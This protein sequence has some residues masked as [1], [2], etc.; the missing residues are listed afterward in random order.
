LKV[1]G[2]VDTAD[3]VREL[4]KEISSSEKALQ[5]LYEKKSKN[6]AACVQQ[7]FFL[8]TLDKEEKKGDALL[9]M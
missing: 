7:D 4:E 9:E 5:A 1:L 2:F 3:S 8:N 6:S